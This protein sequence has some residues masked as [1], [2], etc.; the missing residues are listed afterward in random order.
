MRSSEFLLRS[1]TWDAAYI[2]AR[3]MLGEFGE[4]LPF[5]SPILLN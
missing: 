2:N 5:D 3:K 1:R 4:N